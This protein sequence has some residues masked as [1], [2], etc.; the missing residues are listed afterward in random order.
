MEEEFE[1]FAHCLL[2][3]TDPYP[4][5]THGLVDVETIT[6]VYESAE[7]GRTVELD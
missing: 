4:D 1:Y 3:G 2:T 6:A 5:G 7:S